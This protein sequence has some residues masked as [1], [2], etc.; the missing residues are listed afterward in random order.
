M[1]VLTNLDISPISPISVVLNLQ[2]A[3]G[4]HSLEIT[5]IT[6]YKLFIK[7]TMEDMV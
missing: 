4:E 5:K 6:N 3:T 1:P 2:K 7:E